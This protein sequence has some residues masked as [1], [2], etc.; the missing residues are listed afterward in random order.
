[1][2]YTA[3]TDVRRGALLS[4]L[5]AAVRARRTK[6]DLTIRALAERARVSARFLVQLEGGLGNISV[7][8]LA[9]VADALQTSAAE[10]LREAEERPAALP[11][12]AP[13]L[14]ALLGLRGAGKSA[15]GA[16]VARRLKVPFVE[17]DQLIAREAGMNLATI[18]EMH[19]EAYFQRVEHVAL[20]KFLDSAP[21]AV[22][23]TGG[24][25]VTH[26]ESFELLRD[27]AMTV[28][29]KARPKDHW[30]RVVA[31]GDGRPM[32]DRPA[33]MSELRS[34]LRERSPLYA[35]ATHVV[36][37]SSMSLDLATDKIVAAALTSRRKS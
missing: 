11:D 12:G 20:R 36:D 15:L 3:H 21:A 10:L 2:N 23:A 25:L 7:A 6:R 13:S 4:G 34:L 32:K 1:M 16:R 8:R 27:R 30:D 35:Q 22:L 17:L 19:G 26:A 37:T 24:S 33:A 28:W 31:Q 14:V 18:W 9:D 29:L 5:G